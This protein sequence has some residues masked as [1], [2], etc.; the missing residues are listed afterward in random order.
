M[1][2]KITQVTHERS[3]PVALRDM[4]RGDICVY[5]GEI[6]QYIG[7]KDKEIRLIYEFASMRAFYVHEDEHVQMVEA[8]LT[9]KYV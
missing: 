4:D 3:L 2:L 7:A 9:W 5:K 1:T 8:S 6:C